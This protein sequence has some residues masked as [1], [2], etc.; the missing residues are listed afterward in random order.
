MQLS[1]EQQARSTEQTILSTMV[2][3][4]LRAAGPAGHGT[5]LDEPE[6]KRVAASADAV[7]LS[8]A[9]PASG[10][11][12]AISE[13]GESESDSSASDFQNLAK[14]LT[15]SYAELASQVTELSD[16]LDA[17]CLLYTSPSP[18][19]G[20]LSRMPSSA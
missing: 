19:D 4:A 16:Q 7:G 17:A 9:I 3:K 13:S 12:H 10:T 18:R 6:R 14:Q 2:Q 8:K 11:A 15:D 1:P 5:Q 20:L